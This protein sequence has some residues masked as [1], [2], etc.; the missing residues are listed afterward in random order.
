MRVTNLADTLTR[1]AAYTF[2]VL[3]KDPAFALTAIITLALGIGANT[4]IFTVV[5]AVLLRPLQY[6]DPDRVVELSRGATPIRLDLLQQT[7]RSYIGIGA[8]ANLGSSDDVAL[9]GD[10]PPE[11]I[12]QSRVSANFLSILGVEPLMGRSFTPEE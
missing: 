6:R 7:A 10:F 5:R 4:A 2:R 3:R 11:V 1:D 8:Y 12:K 9:T